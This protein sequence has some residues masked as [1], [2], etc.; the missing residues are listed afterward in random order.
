MITFIISILFFIVG[1]VLRPTI[2]KLIKNNFSQYFTS[3]LKRY[4]IIFKIEYYSHPSIHH[5]GGE[6]ILVKTEPIKVQVDAESE[7]EAL[8]SLDEI[9]KQEIKSELIAIKEINR[10]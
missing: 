5:L 2:V 8:S 3:K 4:E 6:G 7:D 1:L 9:V 10:L